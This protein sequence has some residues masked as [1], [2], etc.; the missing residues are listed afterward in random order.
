MAAAMYC[1]RYEAAEQIGCSRL[2]KNRWR[3]SRGYLPR[4][5]TSS[6]RIMNTAPL[7]EKNVS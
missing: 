1:H 6:L 3:A 2:K 7:G 5:S 4:P